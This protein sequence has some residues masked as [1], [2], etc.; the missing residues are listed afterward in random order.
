MDGYLQI[1]NSNSIAIA[2]RYIITII[3]K[4]KKNKTSV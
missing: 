1:G 4:Y 2:K 3:I